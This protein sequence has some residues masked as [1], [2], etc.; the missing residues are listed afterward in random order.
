MTVSETRKYLTADEHAALRAILTQNGITLCD[1]AAHASLN[2]ACAVNSTYLSAFAAASAAFR[3]GLSRAGQTPAIP[4]TGWGT[5]E[6]P[7]G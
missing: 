4:L 3:L 2:P 6:G 7:C 1:V 5:G